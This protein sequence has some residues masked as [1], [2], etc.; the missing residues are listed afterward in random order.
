MWEALLSSDNWLTPIAS[1]AN[2]STYH[3]DIM[4]PRTPRE[5]LIPDPESFF[6]PRDPSLAR[7]WEFDAIPEADADARATESDEGAAPLSER[8]RHTVLPR[9]ESGEARPR[10]LVTRERRYEIV[11][12]L[13]AGGAGDVF[14]AE[15]RD[16]GRRVAIKKV[17]HAARSER[18]LLRFIHEVR[19][20]GRL[21]H[22][23]VVPI[24]DVGQDEAGD[25]YF[26]MKYVEGVTLQ[27]VIEQLASGDPSM[28]TRFGIERRVQLV[29]G[30]MEALSFAHAQGIV[31][32]DLKPANVMVGEY[33]EA[34]LLDWGIAKTVAD[35]SPG[36]S[37]SVEALSNT[38]DGVLIGTPHY[39]SPEQAR[40]EAVDP[41]SDIYSL[42]VLLHE[43]L[44]LRH[45]LED[46]DDLPAVLQGVIERPVPLASTVAH[47]H[48][49][50]VPMDLSWFIDKGVQKDPANRYPS[51]QEMLEGLRER[52]EGKIHVQ[53]PVTFTKRAMREAER[54]MDRY[55]V[56]RMTLFLSA[57]AAGIL[58]ATV[59]MVLMVALLMLAG[60]GAV[61]AITLAITFAV[62]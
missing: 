28:H 15:D 8:E 14:L 61:V 39:M 21:E 13:G 52:S 54:V 34:L 47:P 7:T 59:L 22:P 5:T 46:L 44:T 24:H 55:L 49:E 40:K 45:Y 58:A 36:G 38:R 42:S 48:Q 10:F 35:L 53:C 11:K 6:E 62:T 26:V 20:I 56:P 32:R 29:R 31:H 17:P 50:P 27:E 51:V 12:M 57:G 18:A 1:C 19:T 37:G 25:Y 43:L 23:N 60:I 30:L 9:V 4:V 2:Q 16:I 33:G 3:G 41:R